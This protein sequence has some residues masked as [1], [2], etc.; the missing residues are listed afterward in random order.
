[1]MDFKKVSTRLQSNSLTAK[2][3][4]GGGIL[5]MGS[6]VEN[7]L[8]FARNMILA[9]IWQQKPLNRSTL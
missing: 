7:L 2:F 9:R 1:M 3:A 8:R 6:F 4:K 5:A